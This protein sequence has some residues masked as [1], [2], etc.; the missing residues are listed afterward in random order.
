M[1]A[2]RLSFPITLAAVAAV[3]AVTALAG[4][5]LAQ[6]S[7]RDSLRIAINR[8]F[9]PWTS[10][11][12]PGC[13]VGVSQN[14][15]V[16]FENGY[17]MAN[18][19]H[20]VPITPASI[21]HVA[22]VSKQFTAAAI[23]LLVREGKLSLDDEVRKHVPEVPAY[24]QRIT[25]RQL[26]HHTS[27]LRDQWDLLIMARGRFEEDRVTEDD[28]LEIVSRQ[29]ALNF[30]PGTEYLYSNT[31]YTLAG[32]IVRRVSGKPLRDF[33]DERIFRPLGMTSTHFHDDYT[34][35]V[36]GRTAGY[37]RRGTGWRVSLPNYDTYGA[38]SLY[39]TV[40]DLLKWQRNFDSRVVGDEAMLREMQTSGI[41]ARGDTTA[42]GLGLSTERYRGARLVGH[43]GADAGYRTYLG[44]FPDHGVSITVLCNASAVNPGA[45]ARS[46]ADVVLDSALAP[47][48]PPVRATASPSGD[49]LAR[50]AGVYSHPLTGAPTYITLRGK[51]LVLGRT[52]GPELIAL[53]ETRFRVGGGPIQLSLNQAGDLVQ[54]I[55]AWPP[56]AAVT[57]KRQPTKTLSRADL[58]AYAGRYYSEELGAAYTVTATDSTLGLKTRLGRALTVRHAYGDTFA[59][60]MLLN[61]TRDAG[62]RV[63]GIRMSSNRVFHVR[64]EREAVR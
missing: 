35:I 24:P 55:V 11:N 16:V 21:F 44:R 58:E 29:K 47:V 15:N 36:K 33:A 51:T 28:V 27:G 45:L 60:D 19:E 20:D 53:S 8:V 63:D 56:R 48:P 9:A 22:S 18:L 42:Y 46:V 43:G 4:P 13:A 64:F 12:A 50:M 54:T 41:L 31:G 61:F 3:A 10:T 2:S 49:Q 34:M 30:E 6:Q 37:A 32:A 59:G 52:N 7:E 26:L 14:G 5:A 40:G 25:I 39:T 17:G 1:T 23:M 62:G 38:T 57:F